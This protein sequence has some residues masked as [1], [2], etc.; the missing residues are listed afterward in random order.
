M[1]YK[2]KEL[3]N[4][5]LFEEFKQTRISIES[6]RNK[7]RIKVGSR[8]WQYFKMAP[9]NE[10]THFIDCEISPAICP[11]QWEDLERDFSSLDK[12]Y[13]EYCDKS[14]YKVDNEFMM[15]KMQDENKCMAISSTLV[16][17]LNGK[18]ND[19]AYRNLEYRLLISKLFL[20]YKDVHQD[21]FKSFIENDF[22]Q[23]LILKAILLDILNSYD[24]EE[25][26]TWYAKRDIDLEM[27]FNHVLSNI[28]DEKFKKQ[29]EEKIDRIIE[30]KKDS[31]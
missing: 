21:E 18:M 7:N 22:S 24:I 16:E 3:F 4:S 9:I 2:V 13:C 12:R 1:N 8:P 10:F 14:V 5:F 27:I 19:D 15:K 6:K 31:R 17:K 23:M 11:M 26:F 20:V 28:E 29:V 25:T 30:S